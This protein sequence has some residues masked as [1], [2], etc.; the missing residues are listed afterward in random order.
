MRTSCGDS[1]ASEYLVGSLTG[2]FHSEFWAGKVCWIVI[3]FEKLFFADRKLKVDGLKL[4]DA[5]SVLK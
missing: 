3:E 1:N 4:S 2:I 5:N